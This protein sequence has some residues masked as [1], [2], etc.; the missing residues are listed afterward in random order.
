MS[1]ELENVRHDLDKA[2]GGERL[3]VGETLARHCNWKVGGPADLFFKAESREELEVA[4]KIA[5][6]HACP[7]TILGFG[8]NVLVSDKGVRGLVILNRAERL[9]FHPDF[10][11]EVDSGTNLAFLARQAAKHGVG[12][13]EF[14][15]GIPGT[16]GGAVYGNAGTGSRWISHILHET[17]LFTEESQELI[18]ANSEMDFRYR[19]SRLKGTGEVLLTAWLRGYD[20][21]PAKVEQELQN[22][23]DLRQNQPG[24]PSTGSVFMNPSGD[25]AGRLI[26]ASGLKGQSVGGAKV[27]DMHANFILNSGGATAADIHELILFIQSSVEENFGV[28][29]QEEIRYLGEFS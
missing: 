21:N 1:Q 6:A 29:L 26:E 5:R 28:R 11:V 25:Y 16:V 22:Q 9:V 2:L 24:G 18:V 19:F 15:I 7:V 4:L 10:M 17:C 27:S 3:S 13:L 20:E 14:L 23:L 8:A 12:G